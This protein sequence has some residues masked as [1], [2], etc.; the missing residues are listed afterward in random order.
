MM[1]EKRLVLSMCVDL[2]KS[3]PLSILIAYFPV[4]SRNAMEKRWSTEECA[5]VRGMAGIADLPI[6]EDAPR[7]EIVNQILETM[8]NTPTPVL[9]ACFRIM[10][11]HTLPPLRNKPS[12]T[13]RFDCLNIRYGQQF[14]VHEGQ[15]SS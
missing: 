12:A 14:A 10:R 4:L 7:E 9:S 8:A 15:A 2:M 3:T 5:M 1:R 13:S 11:E 6:Q